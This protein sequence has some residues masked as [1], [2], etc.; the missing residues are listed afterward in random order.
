MVF[1]EK[2]I[3]SYNIE[4]E[5]RAF[6]II[7]F[8]EKKGMINKERRKSMFHS[9]REDRLLRF[10]NTYHCK[11]NDKWYNSESM[12][13]ILMDVIGKSSEKSAN[14]SLDEVLAYAN[15]FLNKNRNY[16]I[17]WLYESIIKPCVQSARYEYKGAENILAEFGLK[18][19]EKYIPYRD[20]EPHGYCCEDCDV[21]YG[22]YKASQYRAEIGCTIAEAY[23]VVIKEHLKSKRKTDKFTPESEVLR[24]R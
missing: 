4:R 8:M 19:H 2:L 5:H 9:L 12:I 24:T 14:L 15:L 6:L 13:D 18:I 10:I 7:C 23:D 20:F 22:E 16:C 1:P 3:Y 21:E 11:I 17:D